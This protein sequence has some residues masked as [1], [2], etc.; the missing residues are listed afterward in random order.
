MARDR[1][2]VESADVPLE[3]EIIALGGDGV[4]ASGRKVPA[5]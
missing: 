2:T 4:S 5:P 1:P 3:R